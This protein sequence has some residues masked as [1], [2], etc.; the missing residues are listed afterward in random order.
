[1]D[2]FEQDIVDLRDKL[3]WKARSYYK[4]DIFA[5]EDLVQNVMLKMLENK[6]KFEEGTNLTGWAYFI[7]KNTF[8]NEYRTSVRHGNELE[9][10]SDRCSNI[11]TVDADSYMRENDILKLIDK[12]E[13]EYGESFNLHLEGF[14]YYEIAEQMEVP[15]GTVKSRIFLARKKLKEQINLD[16]DKLN[17][18]INVE[19]GYVYVPEP[20]YKSNT[21]IKKIIKNT[22]GNYKVDMTKNIKNVLKIIFDKSNNEWINTKDC[23][24]GKIYFNNGFDNNWGA[25]FNKYLKTSKF[26]GIEG[27]KRVVRFRCYN[28]ETPDYDILA[29]EVIKFREDND[30]TFH[31][32]LKTKTITKKEQLEKEANTIRI[33][34]IKV[35]KIEKYFEEKDERE[36]GEVRHPVK[37]QEIND[38]SCGFVDSIED[39]EKIFEDEE[40][41]EQ[42]TYGEIFKNVEIE[43]EVDKKFRTFCGDKTTVFEVALKNNEEKLQVEPDKNLINIRNYFNIDESC[44]GIYFGNIMEFKVSLV[45]RKGKVYLHNLENEKHDAILYDVCI[46]DIFE[47]PE[48]LV[49]SLINNCIFLN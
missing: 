16:A 32:K 21:I 7:L 47:T 6:D 26:F 2:N 17:Q 8:I 15:I 34:K 12:I 1:M 43:Q 30:D 36:F 40:K 13:P 24:L 45:Q 31:T 33:P 9:L 5:A 10:D 20:E 41:I 49:N 42:N 38:V 29:K 23:S 48:K 18:I 46:C 37:Q 4:N 44:Y 39:E 22:M 19:Q 3:L 28:A 25:I 11:Q 27:D 14:K 35:E